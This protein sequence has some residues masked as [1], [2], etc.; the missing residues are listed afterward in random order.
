MS[1]SITITSEILQVGGYGLTAPE[2]AAIYL[3]NFDGHA[4]LVDAGTGRGHKRLPHV[5]GFLAMADRRDARPV[6]LDFE[7]TR[8]A[9]KGQA[10]PPETVDRDG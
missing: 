5:R 1:R 8:V 9:G 4:A 3:I 6:Q 7:K 10:F 2:D